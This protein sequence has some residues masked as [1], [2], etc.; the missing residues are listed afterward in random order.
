MPFTL[1]QAFSNLQE[2][3]SQFITTPNLD[4]QTMKGLINWGR[5]DVCIR[6]LPYKREF[7]IH[8]AQSV[9]DGATVPYDMLGS[10]PLRV[11]LNSG[12]EARYFKPSEFFFNAGG[13]NGF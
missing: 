12:I 3:L 9:S 4:V 7:F 2:R 6:L 11:L 10:R 8:E 5:R 1:I 13:I